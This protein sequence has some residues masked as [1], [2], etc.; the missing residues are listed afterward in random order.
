MPKWVRCQLSRWPWLEQTFVISFHQPAATFF[1]FDRQCAIL[2]S[3]TVCSTC[4]SIL[5]T[6]VAE[7]HTR[8]ATND[9]RKHHDNVWEYRLLNRIDE[10]RKG[11]PGGG[12]GE[13]LASSTTFEWWP[14]DYMQAG[15]QRDVGLRGTTDRLSYFSFTYSLLLVYMYSTRGKVFTFFTFTWTHRPPPPM[16]TPWAI[17]HLLRT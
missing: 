14:A 3:S 9:I 15:W 7:Y 1:P 2:I 12:G 11:W 13:R 6:S 10:P 17:V 5:N 8:A 4:Y 16:S